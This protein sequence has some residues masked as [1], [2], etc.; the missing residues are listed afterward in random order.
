MLVCVLV[1]VRVC[2]LACAC[3]RCVWKWAPATR[4]LPGN[5]DLH[6]RGGRGAPGGA[7]VVLV[8]GLDLSTGKTGR[9]ARAGGGLVRGVVQM[10]V[11]QKPPET[12]PTFAW[13]ASLPLAGEREVRPVERDRPRF[14]DGPVIPLLLFLFLISLDFS[15]KW[16]TGDTYG[17]SQHM[18]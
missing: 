12:D 13:F 6:E 8:S 2:V 15:G 7:V 18:S 10:Q 9:L 16:V 3:V 5:R 4:P 1:C 11:C 14:A 17:S